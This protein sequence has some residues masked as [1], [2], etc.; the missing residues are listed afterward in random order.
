VES[1]RAGVLPVVEGDALRLKAIERVP[2]D[3]RERIREHKG[4]L[5]ELLSPREAPAG[6]AETSAPDVSVSETP[7]T[8]PV[9]EGFGYGYTGDT[10]GA[11][12][13]AHRD[14]PGEAAAPPAADDADVSLAEPAKGKALADLHATEAAALAHAGTDLQ[15]LPTVA[16]VRRD[17][18]GARIE[19]VARLGPADERLPPEPRRAAATLI[20]GAR[21][22]GDTGEA[23]A[24]R[25]AWRERVAICTVDGGLSEGEAQEVAAEELIGR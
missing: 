11:A 14:S 12:S 9:S 17:F 4:E 23:V 2:P 7:T 10:P 20:R 5:L 22:R 3:L 18:S 16:A 13:E 25:D 8:A 1:V 15:E 6:D 24:L 19:A 21:R